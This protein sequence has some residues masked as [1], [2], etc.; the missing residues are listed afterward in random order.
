MD[1]AGDGE[2]GLWLT[3][4]NNYDAVVLDI[5]LAKLDGLTI[6]R[7]WRAKGRNTHI[8]LLTAKDTVGDRVRS[9][10]SGADD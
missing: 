9:L 3:E 1:I 5:V 4:T 2:E 8:L 7:Q 6:I 10:A